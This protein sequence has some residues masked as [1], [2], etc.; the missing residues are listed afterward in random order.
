MGHRTPTKQPLVSVRPLT[1]TDRLEISTWRY[2]GELGIYDPGSGALELLPPQHV[3]LVNA[4]G[5]LLGYG[6]MGPDARVPGG[7]YDSDETVVDLGVGLHPARVGEGHGAIALEALIAEL[8]RGGTTTR[9]RVT[10]AAVNG[11]ATALA[12][13]LGFQ[14]SHRFT[15]AS[16]GR[17][18]VQYER[19]LEPGLDGSNSTPG[20]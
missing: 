20:V 1:D 17:D 5:T 9:L 12:L 7:T 13:T 19:P 18:F 4:G 15:R 14:A 6:T 8:E 3:A 10:V 11:R 16:D 2:V